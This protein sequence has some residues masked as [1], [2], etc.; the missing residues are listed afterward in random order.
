MTELPNDFQAHERWRQAPLGDHLN[1]RKKVEEKGVG[2]VDG[3]GHF[4]TACLRVSHLTGTKFMNVARNRIRKSDSRHFAPCS[5][6][7]YGHLKTRQM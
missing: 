5:S 1:Y 4:R 3:H 6:Q 2:K 7:C